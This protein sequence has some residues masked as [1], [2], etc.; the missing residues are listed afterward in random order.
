M[1]PIFSIRNSSF[2]CFYHSGECWKDIETNL[3][4]FFVA[5][6][7]R[8]MLQVFQAGVSLQ[9]CNDLRWFLEQLIDAKDEIDRAFFERI[10]FLL[11]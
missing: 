9:E 3:F 5:L 10:P 7:F 6:S 11:K 4:F 1:E 2:L 8:R